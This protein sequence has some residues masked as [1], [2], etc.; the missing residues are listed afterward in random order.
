LAA[1]T[2]Y[3]RTVSIIQR[4]EIPND[5]SSYINC[6]S[7]NLCGHGGRV[8]NWSQKSVKHEMGN[9]VLMLVVVVVV[10]AAAAAA[11]SCLRGLATAV[12]AVNCCWPAM[13]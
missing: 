5:G 10:V 3:G 12:A 2:S 7:R 9:V 13:V 4:K 11:L 1:K 6:E 8:I